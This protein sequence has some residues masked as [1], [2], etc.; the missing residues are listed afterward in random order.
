MDKAEYLLELIRLCA[1]VDCVTE[2]MCK[3]EREIKL[4]IAEV[5]KKQEDPD[6]DK[7]GKTPE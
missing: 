2:S 3:L 4:K 5:T 6:G 7:P 1:V